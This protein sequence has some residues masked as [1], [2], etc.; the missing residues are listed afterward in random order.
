MGTQL[1]GQ[2]Q[3]KGSYVHL[4]CHTKSARQECVIFEWWLA[5]GN[6]TRMG[7]PEL[8]K[9]SNELQW[10]DGE[11]STGQALMDGTTGTTQPSQPQPDV[12]LG[13]RLQV[14]RPP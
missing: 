12:L 14:V 6:S 13:T 3:Q 11:N 4:P 5:F 1:D 7:R 10:R 9:G 2:T 8:T